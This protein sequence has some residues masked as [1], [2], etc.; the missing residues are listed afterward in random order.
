[1]LTENFVFFSQNNDIFLFFFTYSINDLLFFNLEYLDYTIHENTCHKCLPK[2]N[3]I[4]LQIFGESSE[5]QKPLYNFY[6]SLF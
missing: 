6:N 1:M 2:I 3:F 4:F 5:E